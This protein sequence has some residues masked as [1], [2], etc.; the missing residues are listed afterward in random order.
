MTSSEIIIIII[1]NWLRLILILNH[2]VWRL[3]I[4]KLLIILS[5]VT[6]KFFPESHVRVRDPESRSLG[7][8]SLPVFC[9][10]DRRWPRDPAAA[11]PAPHRVTLSD[12]HGRISNWNYWMELKLNFERPQ[13]HSGRRSDGWSIELEIMIMMFQHDDSESE[14]FNGLSSIMIICFIVLVV[15]LPVQQS[16]SNSIE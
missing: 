6:W 4:M 15:T 8:H 11:P 7:C 13:C 12:C 1:I 3:S 9:Q 10:W 14:Y 16:D 2:H 5:T